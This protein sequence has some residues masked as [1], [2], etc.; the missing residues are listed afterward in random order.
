MSVWHL[1]HV[2]ATIVVTF[3]VTVGVGLE[4]WFEVRRDVNLAS[5]PA[6]LNGANFFALA[7]S[8]NIANG[9]CQYVNCTQ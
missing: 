9:T 8:C 6:L 4:V 7:G 2:L 5:A 1:I 3:S